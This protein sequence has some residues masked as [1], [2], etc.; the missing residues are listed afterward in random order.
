MCTP[1]KLAKA[2]LEVG[3]TSLMKIILEAYNWRSIV[4][5]GGYAMDDGERLLQALNLLLMTMGMAA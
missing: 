5:E 2:S 3:V 4:Y 1:R